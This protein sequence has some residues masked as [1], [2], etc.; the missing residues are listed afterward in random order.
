MLVLYLQ[1]NIA[2][3]PPFWWKWMMMLSSTW[4]VWSITW[5]IQPLLGIH[6]C[7]KFG[8]RFDPYGT[9]I[10]NGDAY[11][12]GTIPFVRYV[13]PE[14]WSADMFP[15]YCGGPMYLLGASA[16]KKILR[17]LPSLA[18]FKMEVYCI[19]ASVQFLFRMYFLQEL[20]H[21]ALKFSISIGLNIFAI[22]TRFFIVESISNSVQE[23]WWGVDECDKDKEPFLFSVHS[24]N[25]TENMKKGYDMLKRLKCT[26]REEMRRRKSRTRHWQY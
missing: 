14:D 16:L 9:L 19:S 18:L 25:S 12:K 24:M 6:F 22:V 11:Y 10:A 20:L 13:S 2:L 15:R 23:L 21:R 1:K 4:T 7:V 5:L 3:L 26:N 8:P 17:K